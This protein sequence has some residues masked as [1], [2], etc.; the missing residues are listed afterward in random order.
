[1]EEILNRSFGFVKSVKS[2]GF[3]A[4]FFKIDLPNHPVLE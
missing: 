2:V 4:F 1:M 3:D